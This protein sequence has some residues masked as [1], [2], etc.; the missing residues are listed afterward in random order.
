MLFVGVVSQSVL[1]V[2]LDSA[3]R[4]KL[5]K[6]AAKNPVALARGSSKKYDAL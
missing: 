4:E 6:N 5:T 1:G 3:S 2:N